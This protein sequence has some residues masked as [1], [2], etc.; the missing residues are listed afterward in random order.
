DYAERLKGDPALAALHRHRLIGEEFLGVVSI[1]GTGSRA[2]LGLG[3]RG[4]DRL[5]HFDRHQAP[6]LAALCVQDASGLA[7]SSGAIG[8]S[9]AAMLLKRSPS[10][11]ESL[12]H[13]C[14]GGLLER[15]EILSRGG[16]NSRNTHESLEDSPC[17][18]QVS[19]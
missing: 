8:E 16:I 3:D 4:F 9:G 6:E 15:A 18:P 19:P 2:L 10:A 12:V 17:V 7:H 13:L 11:L 5:A 1:I 14:G